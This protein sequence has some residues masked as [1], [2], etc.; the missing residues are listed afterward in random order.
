[1]SAGSAK[2]IDCSTIRLSSAWGRISTGTYSSQR[3][4][5]NATS[6]THT[7]RCVTESGAAGSQLRT[8]VQLAPTARYTFLVGNRFDARPWKSGGRRNVSLGTCECALQVAGI[9]A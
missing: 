9:Q 2:R 6:A 5:A 8:E 7:S 3:Y 1:S 4:A